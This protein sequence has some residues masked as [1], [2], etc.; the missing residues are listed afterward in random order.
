VTVYLDVKVVTSELKD[1]TVF[2]L[3]LILLATVLIADLFCMYLS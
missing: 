2:V 1:L 3:V